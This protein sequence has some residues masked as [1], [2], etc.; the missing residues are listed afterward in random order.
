MDESDGGGRISSKANKVNITACSG[1][2]YVGELG[3][4]AVIKVCDETREDVTELISIG[5]FGKAYMYNDTTVLKH[6]VKPIKKHKTIAVDGCTL[7][8]ATEMLKFMGVPPVESIQVIGIVKGETSRR[9]SNITEE[10]VDLVREKIEAAVDRLLE[11]AT[12]G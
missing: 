10:E 12:S 7:N 5:G 4:R 2:N 3:R 9:V 8:C 6:G 1:L 11:E